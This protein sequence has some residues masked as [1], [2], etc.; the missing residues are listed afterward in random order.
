MNFYAHTLEGEP[1]EKWEPLFSADCPFPQRALFTFGK[2]GFSSINLPTK[3][4]HH[5]NSACV[6]K[7]PSRHPK[8]NS[9][10]PRSEARPASAIRRERRTRRN[11][12]NPHTG[13]THRISQKRQAF[14]IRTRT[15]SQTLIH[16]I[17]Q[18]SIPIL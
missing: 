3:Y 12:P 8:G 17:L 7:I 15:R 11:P 13:S 9:T 1:E 2:S 16:F 10:S 4:R 6:P 18:Y 5:D 14:E